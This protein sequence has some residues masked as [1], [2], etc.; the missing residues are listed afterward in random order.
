[1]KK[2][3]LI[4]TPRTP[5]L[6]RGADEQDRLSGI[7]WFIDHGYEV[8]VI[9]KVTEHDSL[10]IDEAKKKLGITIIPILYRFASRKNTFE[11]I[12]TLVQ[13]LLWPPYWDGASYE[14]FDPAIQDEYKRQL[15]DFKPDIAWFDYSYLWPLYRF[16]QAKK[17]PIVTRSINMEPIHFLDED[18]GGIINS[19]RSLP[20]W[21]SEYI[22][23]KKSD[24]VFAITPKE[25]K[26]YTKLGA[27]AVTL[28]LRGLPKV[29]EE[30]TIQDVKG[31][32][33]HIG[34]TASTYNV[35]HNLEALQFIL[36]QVLP[37]LHNKERKYVFHFTGLKLP[38]S[39]LKTI[40]GT[41][42]IYEGF[43]PS[44]K[45]F[46]KNMDIAIIP[47]LFGAGM[48]QK[49]FEPITLGVPTVTSERAISGYG[50]VGGEDLLFAKSADDFARCV[51]FFAQDLEKMKQISKSATRTSRKLF[52][53]EN[54]DSI[55]IKNIESL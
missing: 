7:Q 41:N 1:M 42:V 37:L 4:T 16:A 3:I 18:G 40:D 23:S 9:T 17:L 6:G 21:V 36:K 50:F 29:F 2:K 45:E 47:S 15:E 25:E 48:Q 28:P 33:I 14:Y 12:K 49:V 43:V 24:I 35:A 22:V 44:M 51:T 11:K 5:F 38:E 10:H 52:S 32:S 31:R 13:R 34:F 46:W 20:K 26:I 54:I 27:H 39:I 53:K 8:R 30:K 19:I 55:L